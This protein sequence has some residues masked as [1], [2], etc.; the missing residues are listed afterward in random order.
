MNRLDNK[1]TH[2]VFEP[3]FAKLL[4]DRVSCLAITGAAIAQAILVLFD[5][6][7]WICPTRE[8]LGCPCPGCGLTRAMTAMLAGDIETMLVLHALAPFFAIGLLI[9]ALASV[10]SN[11]NRQKLVDLVAQ[12]EMQTGSVT[13]FLLTLVFYWLI[14]LIFFNQT[15]I[16]LIFN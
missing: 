9:I 2:H 14:R 13:I 16:N 7:G 1:I 12:I 4:A 3:V 10:L 11:T 15:Y 6:P 8:Y 5:K